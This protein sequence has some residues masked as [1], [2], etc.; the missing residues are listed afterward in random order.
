MFYLWVYIVFATR[1]QLFFTKNRSFFLY[2]IASFQLFLRDLSNV[3]KHI[4][5]ETVYFSVWDNIETHLNVN[6]ILL[7]NNMHLLAY[8]RLK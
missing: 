3:M 6:P 8:N 7:K 5:F 1:S 2:L 4:N